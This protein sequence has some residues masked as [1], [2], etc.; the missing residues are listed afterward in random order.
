MKK[1]IF[2]ICLIIGS[3][4]SNVHAQNLVD[5]PDSNFRKA[6]K[7][8]PSLTSCFVGDKMDTTCAGVKNL[9]VLDVSYKKIISFEGIKWF[10]NLDSLIC[11]SNENKTFPNLPNKL[12]SLICPVGLVASLP[13]LPASLVLLRCEFNNLSTLPNLPS[14]LKTLWCGVNPIL[15]L[16][17]IPA[18]LVFLECGDNK[19]LTNLP[20][21]PDGLKELRCVKTSLRSLP[22]L[23]NSLV[24][25]FCF[26]NDLKSLPALP[27]SLKSLDCTGNSL[28]CLPFLPSGLI[29]LS[30]NKGTCLP[31]IPNE[32]FELKDFLAK[33]LPKVLCDEINNI[34]NCQSFPTLNGRVY[35]DVNIDK[36]YTEGTDYPLVNASV[37]SKSY[38]TNVAPSG[39]FKL[40][41]DSLNTTYTISP[42]LPLGFT[43]KPASD[44]VR[45]SNYN[46]VRTGKDFIITPPNTRDLAIEATPITFARPGFKVRYQVMVKNMGGN[47]QDA[48]AQLAYDP[49]FTFESSTPAGNAS[50]NSVSWNIMGL[51]PFEERVFVVEFTLSAQTPLGTVL[52]NT[53]T[54]T[55]STD[56]VAAN[57]TSEIK[58]TVRGSY[59][60]NDK[61]VNK[62]NAVLRSSI[63]AQEDFVYTIRF[64]NTGTDT[65][66]TVVVRDTLAN[67]FE[68]SSMQT[69][70]SSHPYLYK[71]KGNVATWT[72]NNIL[73]PDSNTNS[74]G[75]NGF[76]KFKIKP[77]S[78]LQLND[79]IKNTAYIYFDFNTAIKTNIAN[80]RVSQALAVED[81]TISSTIYPNPSK[82]VFTV[83]LGQ[84]QALIQ[85]LSSTGKVVLEK[86]ASLSTTIDLNG[87]SKGIYFLK[88]Q[89]NGSTEVKKLIK[90]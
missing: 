57:N 75:S 64:Q 32:Y 41:F 82:G 66:F 70:A 42:I 58:Q 72:F 68:I 14:S 80:T 36:A 27:A 77:L 12:R 88:I 55:T 53:A 23:P 17:E 46:E 26:D 71:L 89:S 9:K 76:I 10:I 24:N 67:M 81:E 48:T 65:A 61:L 86:A 30:V 74:P 40:T 25:L 54:I 11:G 34:N 44:T 63:Q 73:L 78:T 59:D 22:K 33:S 7:K 31:N 3:F 6:L 4:L 85:V 87:E 16:P 49:F 37:K 19:K 84:R 62:G 60:P 35:I 18:G 52:A 39:Q 45:F 28:S 69:T 21:L 47:K 2:S 90:E 51:K 83:E 13:E 1:I 38:S 56:D 29:R 43:S 5:I 15:S 79:E 50:G 20:N 8:I